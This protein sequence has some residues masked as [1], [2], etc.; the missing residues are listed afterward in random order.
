MATLDPN[1]S[2]QDTHIFLPKDGSRAW[3]YTSIP[4]NAALSAAS[5][6]QVR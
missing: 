2:L 5:Q 6:L 3:N 1:F 4:L